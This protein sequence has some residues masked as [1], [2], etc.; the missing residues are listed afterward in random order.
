MDMNKNSVMRQQISCGA[1]NDHFKELLEIIV[2]IL[3][4]AIQVPLLR[5]RSG[6]SFP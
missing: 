1:L 3:F 4:S 6:Q 5:E 2:P